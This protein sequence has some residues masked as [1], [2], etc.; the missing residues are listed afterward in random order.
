M[1]MITGAIILNAGVLA[2]TSQRSDDMA[3]LALP[4]GLILLV[5]G[6]V[7]HVRRPKVRV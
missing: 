3:V 2:M 5:W 1:L 7:D 4:L 6:I